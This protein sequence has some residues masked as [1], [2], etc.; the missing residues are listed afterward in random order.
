MFPEIKEKSACVIKPT[1]KRL[2][3]DEA[4]ICKR[5]IKKY[6]PENHGKMARDIK[7]NYLQWSKG[8]VAKNVELYRI[9]NGDLKA[10]YKE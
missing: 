8:Q 2:K 7:I 1:V 5:L 4:E 6:G 9:A 3:F 10:D